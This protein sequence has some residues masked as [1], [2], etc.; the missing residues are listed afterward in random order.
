MRGK[1]IFYF[2]LAFLLTGCATPRI[3]FPETELAGLPLAGDKTVNGTVFLIDQLGEK[4]VGVGSEVTLEPVTSYSEQWYEVSYLKNRSLKK[5]D[6]RYEKYLLHAT[7]D[8]H[9]FFSFTNVAPG[10]YL[11][12]VPFYWEAT[13][14]SAKKAKTKVMITKKIMIKPDDIVLNIP[15]TKEYVSS[16]VV[17]DVYNQGAWEKEGDI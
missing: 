12:S 1:I 3:P 9:G 17:C 11:L 7:A 2:F 6:S 4:Q 15:L 14:C 13:T 5:P 10:S 16:M 8:D